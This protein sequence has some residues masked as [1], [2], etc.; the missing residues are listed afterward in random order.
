VIDE[1]VHNTKLELE[2]TADLM[3]L[4][5][6]GYRTVLDAGTRD[7]YY[8][9]RL[10]EYFE[11]VTA[12]DLTRPQIDCDRVTCV[13]GDLT[14]LSYP[15][16]SFDFVFCSEVLEH[17]PNLEKAVSEIK[18]VARHAILIGVPYK[19]DIRVGRVTCARCGKVSPPWGH[20]NTFDENRLR[21][22]FQ[23]FRAVTQSLVGT[24]HERS[25]ALATWLTDLGRNPYGIYGPE[26]R[27]LHCNSSLDIQPQRSFAHKVFSAAGVRLMK[28]HS[29]MME[30]HANWIHMLFER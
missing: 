19:Q 25:S 13:A 26:Q 6:K 28:A 10:T 11:S 27:C 30:P 22:L 4:V 14:R 16:K 23:P 15:D 2:R 7:G 8:S 17:I 20:V 21:T 9:I 24:D 12:L 29:A 3:R 18:R 1:A 5:P